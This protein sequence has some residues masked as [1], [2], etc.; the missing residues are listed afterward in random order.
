M[1]KQKS[2]K[3]VSVLLELVYVSFVTSRIIWLQ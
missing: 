1:L 3:E 2:T